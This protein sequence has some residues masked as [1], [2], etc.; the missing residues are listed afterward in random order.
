M[1]FISLGPQYQKTISKD[2]KVIGAKANALLLGSVPLP[3][4]E[5]CI[6]FGLLGT[7]YTHLGRPDNE[8]MPLEF[9]EK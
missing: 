7:H 5:N 4:A 1:L 9:S 8:D 6:A 2:P 3:L